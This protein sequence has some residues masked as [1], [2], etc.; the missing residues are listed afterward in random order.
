MARRSGPQIAAITVLLGLA[1]VCI[2]YPLVVAA[3]SAILTTPGVHQGPEP[4]LWLGAGLLVRTALAALL[5]GV[6]ATA[7]AW[8]GAWAARGIGARWLPLMLV[9]ML[10][11]SYLAYS[12]WGLLRAPGTL[13]GDWLMSGPG[14]GANWWPV[15]AGQVLAVLG[16][17]LWSW[18]LAAVVLLAG[19]RRLDRGVLEAIR[20]E[21]R[22]GWS[23]G[24]AILSMTRTSVLAAV[25]VVA[26]VMLGSAVPFHVAQFETYAIE[27][28]RLLNEVP[29]DRQWRVWAAAWPLIAF[30]T[31]A[32]VW[33]GRR[34]VGSDS[35]ES[36]DQGPVERSVPI[37]A[38]VVWFASVV[39][40]VLLFALSL[41]EARSLVRFWT[42][43]DEQV[44]T[45]AAIGSATAVAAA[46]LACAVW[47]GLSGRGATR[48]AV[49]VC[50]VLFL[51]VGLLPGVLVGSVTAAAWNRFGALSWVADS[52]A[53]VAL[54][55]IA[56][57]GFLPALLGWW[58]WR[59]EPGAERDLRA[60]DGADTLA[61][62]FAGPL[63][64]QAAAILGGALAVG[65]L[66][67]HEI[68]A[69]VLLQ[70]PGLDSFARQMLNLL[71]Q[72]R[73]EDLSAAVLTVM[74]GGLAVCGA[75]VLLLSGG[76][77]SLDRRG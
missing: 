1:T 16:L 7:L 6:L 73:M 69:A 44:W 75:A 23:R 29:A 38:A 33:I 18:P 26:L 54:G 9:P 68:E 55:H 58:L 63:R 37:G 39:A 57:F 22:G 61:G 17:S 47:M 76:V 2:A 35:W 62:W 77:G 56:R 66:S 43:S 20:M 21:A 11:P 50:V 65:M 12:G 15:A 31:V 5:V 10:M 36:G 64:T 48:R 13:L 59:T 4:A 71:H 25:A 8:P 70:P 51:V 60:I 24:V 53:A 45:S 40:P 72:S 28:W 3:G 46:A 49:R 41:R 74:A 32:G 30:A 14:E 42:L 34:T 27:I 19:F 52:G 67:F